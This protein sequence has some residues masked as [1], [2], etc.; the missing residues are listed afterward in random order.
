MLSPTV[1]SEFR[2]SGSPMERKKVA[3]RRQT[4]FSHLFMQ[5]ILRTHHV[6]GTIKDTGSYSVSKI[7][8]SHG[9][10]YILMGG[11]VSQEIYIMLVD[12]KCCEEE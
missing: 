12:S 7:K 4:T 3:S 11:Y 9:V 5:Q 2:T 10:L 8:Y 6:L 1:N